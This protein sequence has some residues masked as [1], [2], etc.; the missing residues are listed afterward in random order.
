ML[1][2]ILPIYQNHSSGKRIYHH[3]GFQRI[4]MN[5]IHN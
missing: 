4:N 2:E 5:I 3:I 1:F